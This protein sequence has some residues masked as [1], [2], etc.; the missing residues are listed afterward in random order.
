MQAIVSRE[1]RSPLHVM[2]IV[3]LFTGHGK[4]LNYMQCFFVYSFGKESIL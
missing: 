1:D 4:P 3:I 2:L